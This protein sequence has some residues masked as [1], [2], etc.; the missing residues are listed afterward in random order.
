[1]TDLE[2]TK[3]CA[4]AMGMILSGK[5]R[6]QG[7]YCRKGSY[8]VKFDPLHDDAQ[9]MALVKKFDLHVGKTLRTPT[10][11]RGSWFVSRTD[12]YEVTNADLNRAIV[13]VC[14]KMQAAKAHV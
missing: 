1:M 7:I 4:E 3:L 8:V 5:Q 6:H 12:K 2:M 14:A 13:E 9:A 11:P 10:M